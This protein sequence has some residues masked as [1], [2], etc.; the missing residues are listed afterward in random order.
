MGAMRWVSLLAVL[1]WP[2]SALAQAASAARS[3][4]RAEDV[5]SIDGMLR[6]F[7]D[8]ISGPAGQPR[9]WGRDSSLYI[10]G[11]RFVAMSVRNGRPVAQVM[12][13]AAFIRAVNG[14]FVQQGFFEREIHRVV[15]RFGNIAHVFSTYEFRA[16]ESGPV[17]GRGVNS[18]EMFWDGARWWIAAAIWDDERPDNPILPELLPA[19]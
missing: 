13:H 2:S 6:A 10:D 4:A 15:R 1:V 7:Y 16:T 3:P 14:P 9:Q 8:V 17:Q 18:I 5:G 12:D 19:P 11:V